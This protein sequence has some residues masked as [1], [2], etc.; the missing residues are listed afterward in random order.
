[1][2]KSGHDNNPTTSWGLVAPVIRQGLFEASVD[3]I[4]AYLLKGELALAG[5]SLPPHSTPF[6]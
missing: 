3:M 5:F 4:L 2:R 1:M 6:P